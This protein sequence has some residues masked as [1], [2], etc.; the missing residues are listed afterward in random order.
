MKQ[1]KQRITATVGAILIA[2]AMMVASLVVISPNQAQAKG[3]KKAGNSAKVKSN[4]KRRSA[5][6]GKTYQS[7]SDG[8]IAP[9]TKRRSAGNSNGWATFPSSSHSRSASEFNSQTLPHSDGLT[10]SK[11]KPG[12]ASAMPT[13]ATSELQNAENLKSSVRRKNGA[14]AEGFSIDIGTSENIRSNTE[15]ARRKATKRARQ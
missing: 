9:R 15:G 11:T 13:A 7:V 8:D 3:K 12:S 2:L 10:I 14:G 5:G 1:F 6:N 4:A